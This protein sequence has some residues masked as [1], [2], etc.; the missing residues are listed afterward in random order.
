M[1]KLF[2]ILA[3]LMCILTGCNS[4][5]TADTEPKETSDSSQSMEQTESVQ[6]DTETEAAFPGSYTEPNGW[7]KSE[8][9]STEE[10]IFYVEEGHEMDEQPDNISISIGTNQYGADDHVAF[11]EAIVQQL[12]AQLDGVKAELT[13]DGTYTKQGYPVYI[14]TIEEEDAGIVKNNITLW[15]IMNIV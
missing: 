2:V 15:A 12:L 5:K 9:Y 11:R 13:G 3:M 14:F 7:V 8:K 10:M 6:T 1:K 4:E